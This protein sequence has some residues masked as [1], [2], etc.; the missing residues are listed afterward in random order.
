M[1]RSGRRL[2][3][4]SLLGA[5]VALSACKGSK[6]D[7]PGAKAAPE[8]LPVR[9][10]ALVAEWALA[11]AGATWR[12]VHPLLGAPGRLIPVGPELAL[13]ALLDLGPLTAGAFDF[14]RPVVGGLVAAEPGSLEALAVVPLTSGPELVARLSTGTAAAFRAV[15]AGK[16]MFLEP[17]RN[18]SGGR[19]LGVIDDALLIGPRSA[20]ERSGLYLVRVTARA[21]AT[22]SK[23]AAQPAPLAAFVRR[24]YAERR[25]ELAARAERAQ[26]EHGRPADF[27]DPK[28]ALAA[29]DALVEPM[30][31]ALDAARSAE[32]ELVPGTDRLGLW[33]RLPAGEKAM[34]AP[35][36]APALRAL[37]E[38][39]AAAS[40]VLSSRRNLGAADESAAS[41]TLRALFGA[42][43]TEPRA[44]EL[45]GVF[46]ALDA[47]LGERFTLSFFG[48]LTLS[49]TSDVRDEKQL[50]EGVSKLLGSFVESPWAEPIASLFGKPRLVR[51]PARLGALRAERVRYA[52]PTKPGAPKQAREI[53]VLYWFEPGRFQLV[54]GPDA[55]PAAAALLA[56]RTGQAAFAGRPEFLALMSGPVAA[57]DTVLA[58]D[59]RMVSG[60]AEPA[61]LV[62]G[63]RSGREGFELGLEASAPAVESLTRWGLLP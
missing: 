32:L 54:I 51:A 50:R 20:I 21:P 47:G 58:A 44:K 57:L 15:P 48:D 19:A 61:W 8:P 38:L 12:A 62:A 25:S 29:L 30:F 33:L 2:W 55:D 49:L 52:F 35:A 27:A 5:A 26:A 43:L 42:R 45:Q 59:A 37:A 14:G 9:P 24:G 34:P 11:D 17:A 63:A 46:A 10:S 23:L 1:P 60:V 41:A 7:E 31:R 13:G 22:G 6:H 36:A 28:A 40:V 39:P 16:V 53:E 3:A 56:A 4:A 18:D